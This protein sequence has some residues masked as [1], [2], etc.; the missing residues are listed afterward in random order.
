MHNQPWDD[1]SAP[2]IATSL[3]DFYYY[4]D[5]FTE[6]TDKIHCRYEAPREEPRESHGCLAISWKKATW[7]RCQSTLIN[8][9]LEESVEES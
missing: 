6:S 5:L 2:A 8:I 1:S 9:T 3:S 7:L 4:Y